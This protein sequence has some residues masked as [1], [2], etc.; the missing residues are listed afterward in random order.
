[1][2]LDRLTNEEIK[3]IFTKIFQKVETNQSIVKTTIG[4]NDVIVEK[5]S[6]TMA[7][8]NGYEHKVCSITGKGVYVSSESLSASAEP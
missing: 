5:G 2:I 8:Y 7:L 3:F 6:Y 1:M 4:F